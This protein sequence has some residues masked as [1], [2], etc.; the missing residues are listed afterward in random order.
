MVKDLRS[1]VSQLRGTD[2]QMRY[3]DLKAELKAY[4]LALD[5]NGNSAVTK[6]RS[7]IDEAT[8]AK[9]EDRD[10]LVAIQE[11]IS[12]SQRSGNSLDVRSALFNIL[13]TPAEI[14]ADKVVRRFKK[15]TRSSQY[16]RGPVRPHPF[17][18]PRVDRSGSCYACGEQGHLARDCPSKRK[19]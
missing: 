15:R 12:Y 3:N 1:Q 10:K 8:L 16:L 17:R 14:E 6:L 13:A 19:M 9:S 7:L 2:H 18:C 11:R 4:C 5:F